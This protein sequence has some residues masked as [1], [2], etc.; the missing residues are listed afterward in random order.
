[1]R[2]VDLL[3]YFSVCVGGGGNNEQRCELSDDERE[4]GLIRV[5]TTAEKMEKSCAAAL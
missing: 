1:M 4:K 3:M 2:V 5:S